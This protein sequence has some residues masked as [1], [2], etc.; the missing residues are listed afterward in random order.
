MQG[1]TPPRGGVKDGVLSGQVPSGGKEH[2]RVRPV[3]LGIE[4]LFCGNGAFR[5]NSWLTGGQNPDIMQKI[6]HAAV[7]LPGRLF[8]ARSKG[9]PG[10]RALQIKMKKDE[11][12]EKRIQDESV[13]F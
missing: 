6:D 12:H 4:A 8:D 7:R 2:Q 13:P 10:V 11:G 1:W 5:G 3:Q 9:G